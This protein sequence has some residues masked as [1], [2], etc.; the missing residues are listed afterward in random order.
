MWQ[1]GNKTKAT[2]ISHEK[3]V[4]GTPRRPSRR[5]TSAPGVRSSAV[6]ERRSSQVCCRSFF[7]GL[8]GRSRPGPFQGPGQLVAK[9][10]DRWRLGVVEGTGIAAPFLGD[11]EDGGDINPDRGVQEAQRNR[12]RGQRLP[13]RPGEDVA[14]G[15][16]RGVGDE[17][18]VI[19][20]R[21]GTRKGN[22]LPLE[23]QVQLDEVDVAMQQGVAPGQVGTLLT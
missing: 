9:E 1:K 8:R 6:P 3:S 11:G 20:G 23:Q 14:V 18:E 12:H 21:V 22:P 4:V 16:A 10:G 2:R 7:L 13:H 5:A 19:A 15:T 17:G